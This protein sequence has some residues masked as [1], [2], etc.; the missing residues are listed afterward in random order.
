VTILAAIRCEWIKFR[1]VR[2]TLVTLAVTVVLCVGFS[3][4]FTWIARDNWKSAGFRDHLAFN[5][6]R[7]SLVGFVFAEIAIGVIGVLVITSEYSSGLIRA[8]LTALPHRVDALL[9]KA[10]VLFIVTLVVGEGCSFVSFL[11]GQS[12]LHGVTPSDTLSSPGS[13]R[14]VVLAGLSL[15]LL[16]LFALGLGTMLRHTAGAI[17][18]FVAL[19]LIIWIIVATLPSDY[20]MHIYP[21]LPEVLSQSMRAPGDASLSFSSFSPTVSSLVLAAY[22]VGSLLIGGLVLVRRDA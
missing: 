9:A 15:A 1:S 3:A 21:Y 11:V 10:V 6:T 7:L 12:I 8:T 2:S 22:A 4:L 19:L 14:A 18:V 17:T 13:L 5:P 16:A 20:Q